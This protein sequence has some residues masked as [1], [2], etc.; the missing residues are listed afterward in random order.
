MF[1]LPESDGLLT[2]CTT[3]ILMDTKIE[4]AYKMCILNSRP[5]LAN[6]RQFKL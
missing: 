3:D 2:T 5:C 4:R 6:T 1:I